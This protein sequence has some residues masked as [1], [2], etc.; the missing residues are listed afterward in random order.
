MNK[1]VLD[2]MSTRRKHPRV[3]CHWSGRVQNTQRQIARVSVRNVS[4]GGV[5]IHTQMVLKK[6]DKVLLEFRGI[7]NEKRC[8]IR[9]ICLVAFVV[10]KGN[11]YDVGLQYSSSIDSFRDF[12]TSYINGRT[13]G[14]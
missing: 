8:D 9:A 11:E 12:L 5:G 1:P 2:D 6:G 13:V 7:Y 10:V 14:E 3:T 4:L